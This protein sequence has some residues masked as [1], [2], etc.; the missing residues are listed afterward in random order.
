MGRALLDTK[1]PFTLIIIVDF[2]FHHHTAFWTKGGHSGQ[3]WTFGSILGKL[4]H[5]YG[6]F[7]QL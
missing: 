5:I 1:F 3:I 6:H 7:V 4:G 2:Q